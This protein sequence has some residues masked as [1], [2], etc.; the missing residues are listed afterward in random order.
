MGQPGKCFGNVEEAHHKKTSGHD[1]ASNVANVLETEGRIAASGGQVVR[2]LGA[3]DR[4][5]SCPL[6]RSRRPGDWLPCKGTML[7]T[8]PL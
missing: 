3:V 1:S 4:V 6:A 7:T 8:T 5:E 2:K